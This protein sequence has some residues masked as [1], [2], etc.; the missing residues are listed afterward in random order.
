MRGKTFAVQNAKQKAK[1]TKQVNEMPQE[2][3]PKKPKSQNRSMKCPNKFAL[4]LV[5]I[6]WTQNYKNYSVTA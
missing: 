5:N 6:F 2:A 1:T 3:C 4:A